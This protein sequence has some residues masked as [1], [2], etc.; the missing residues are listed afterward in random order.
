MSNSRSLFDITNRVIVV[1]GATGVLAGSAAKYLVSQ[2]ARVV[3]LA[4]DAAKLDRALAEAKGLPGE[5]VSYPCNVLDQAG[6]EKVRDSVVARFGRVDA[7]INAAGGNQPGATIPP[8]KSVLDLDLAAYRQV[9]DLN[10]DGT[11]IPS[12]VFS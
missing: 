9:V 11:V 8:D 10:L 3:F 2:G 12:L 7:L 1:T 6:L 5:C 4:R